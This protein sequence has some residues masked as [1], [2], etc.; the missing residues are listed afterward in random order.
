MLRIV[1]T[2]TVATLLFAPLA[3]GSSFHDALRAMARGDYLAAASRL[4][5]I[6][7]SRPEA[8]LA[9]LARGR[10]LLLAGHYRQAK[11][12]YASVLDHARP[13]SPY[14]Q[15]A[16]FGMAECLAAVKRFEPAERLFAEALDELTADK[17]R[18]AIAGRFVQLGDENLEPPEGR[19]AD[20]SRAEQFFRAAVEVGATGEM[21]E[22]VKI[23]IG[24]SLAAQNRHLDAA[25]YLDVFCSEHEKSPRLPEALYL[26][27]KAH[28][29]AGQPDTAR[30]AF[31]DLLA[32]HPKA[33][34]APRAAFLLS[35]TFGMPKPNNDRNLSWGLYTLGRY[36]HDWPKD[37][38]HE[39][40]RLEAALAPLHAKRQ[41][42]AEQALRIYI[43]SGGP[44]DN[45][46]SA[47]Y[48]LGEALAAQ[49][50]YLKAAAAFRDYLQKHPAHGFWL[51]ARRGIEDMAFKQAEDAFTG[52]KWKQAIEGF[53]A[54]T[55][56]YPAAARTPQ[57][58]LKQALA[59]I[60]LNDI[61]GALTLLSTLTT[62]FPKDKSAADGWYR[63]GLLLEEK[64]ADIMKAR[65]AYEKATQS[66]GG[67]SH[68]S[69]RLAALDEPGL[70]VESP[71][72]FHS[73]DKPALTWHARNVESVKVNIYH[74]E[75]EDF[76]KDRMQMES[77]IDMDIALCAPDKTFDVPVSGY[78]KHIRITQ[79]VP[80]KIKS[81]G[82]YLVHLM[83]GELEAT[84][85][86]VV[87]DL[88]MIIKNGPGKIFVFSQNLKKTLPMGGT[89]II[90]AD[91]N[92]IVAEGK[93]GKDGV[94]QHDLPEN[95]SGDGL[96][97]LAIRGGHLAWTGIDYNGGQPQTASSPR[98]FIFTDRPAYRPGD[99]VTIAGIVRDRP[100]Q[101]ASGYRPGDIVHIDVNLSQAKL[102]ET[103]KLDEFG[104]F[105]KKITLDPAISAG[106]Y[107]ISV[108]AHR[109][110]AFGC[111][112]NVRRYRL[113]A[114]DLSASFDQ[115]V[116]FR[117]EP[118]EGVIRVRHRSGAPAAFEKISY[119]LDDAQTWRQATC[120]E[121]GQVRFSFPTRAME[122][123]H[124]AVLQMKLPRLNLQ[125]EATAL[126]AAEGYSVSLSAGQKTI[127]AGQSFDLR[128]AVNAPDGKP[129]SANL[130]LRAVKRL[131]GTN[132]EVRVL[133]RKIE[134]PPSGKLC[135]PV[136]LSGKGVHIIRIYGSDRAGH[137][138]SAELGLSTVGEDEP[139]FFLDLERSELT[140]GAPAKMII[141]SHMDRALVLL[142]CET[143]E[144]LN[145]R[146][147]RLSRGENKIEIP[148]S[149]KLVPN[150][151]LAAAAMNKDRLY[152]ASRAVRVT[153]KL[154]LTVRPDHKRY[155]PGDEVNLTLIARDADGHPI[156]ARLVVA[157]VDETL[158]KV[159]PE[160]LPD[161][162]E[163][164]QQLRPEGEIETISSNAYRFP[165]VEASEVEKAE[166]EEAEDSA[167]M[168]ALGAR[169]RKMTKRATADFSKMAKTEGLVGGSM[170]YGM[171]AGGL[172]AGGRGRG[173]GGK[174]YMRM[175]RAQ[176]SGSGALRKYFSQTAA[177]FPALRTGRDGVANVT[178][179][180]PDTLTTWRI[181]TRG[182]TRD[183][184]LGEDRT[185][186][187]ASRQF[188]AELIA[189]P[190]LEEGD[191]LQPAARVY[192]DSR[193]KLEAT[194]KLAV[195]GATFSQAVT[196]KPLGSAEVFFKSLSVPTDS[197]GKMRF[198][199]SAAAGDLSDHLVRELPV[200]PRGVREQVLAS[201]LLIKSTSRTMKLDEGLSSARIDLRLDA[202]LSHIILAGELDPL[203]FGDRPEEALVALNILE[204]IG[205]RANATM[206]DMVM[207]RLR[208]ALRHL[209][210]TQK[211]NGGWAFSRQ[212]NSSDPVMTARAL[213]A[214]A[215]ARKLEGALGWNFPQ[216]GYQKALEILK[217][218]LVSL[219]PND[220]VRRVEVIYAL[221]H[222]GRA[223]IPQVHLQR[224]HR[225][226][227]SLPTGA[228]A[229][230]GL[231]WSLLD[232]PEKAAELAK[233]IR[234]ALNQAASG[235]I[236]F[237]WQPRWND[238]TCERARAL[239][240]LAQVAPSDPLVKQGT[241]WLLGGGTAFGWLFPEQAEAVTAA[242]GKTLAAP[243]RHERF[244][245]TISLNGSKAASLSFPSAEGGYGKSLTID[246]ALL[247]TG[248]NKLDLHLEGDGSCIFLATLSGYRAKAKP[249]AEQAAVTLK[250][251]VEPLPQPYRGHEIAGGFSVVAG[252]SSTWI[253]EI[254]SIPAGRRVRVTL[255]IKRNFAT[256]LSHCVLDERIP[257]GFELVEG[258]QSGYLAHM[259]QSGRRLAF[260][261]SSSNSIQTISY[262][263]QAT[264]P[265]RY[266]FAPARLISVI[267]PGT[268]VLSAGRIFTIDPPGARE[269]DRRT[270]PDELYHLGLAAADEK[271]PSMVIEKL[272]QLYQKFKLRENI[273]RDVQARLLF[274]SI[275]LKD[276]QRIVK[277]FEL[278]KEKNPDLVIPFDKIAPL[279]AA[280]RKVGS[281]EAGLHLDRGVCD[282][283]FMSEV[284]GVGILETQDEMAE[285]IDL[286][287]DQLDSYPDAE[288]AARATYAFSQVLFDRADRLRSGEPL[289][290]FDRPGLI[291][292]VVELMSRYLGLFPADPQAPAAVYSLASALLER[293][294]PGQAIDWC[295]AGLHRFPET[296]LSPAIAYLQAFAHF[297]LGQY[298]PSLKLCRQVVD[299]SPD[300]ENQD[301]ARYIMA[302]IFHA[303]GQLER[304]LPLYRMVR[305]S[306][307]DAEETVR[308]S[309][310]TLLVV[311]EV[312]TVPPGKRPT[313]TM[314]VRNLERINLRAYRVDPMSLYLVKGSL[315]DL[316]EVNLAGIKPV[317]ATTLRLKKRVGIT[318]EEKEPLRLP[319]KGAYL[320]L[321]HAGS[322]AEHSL[323]MVGG[324]SLDVTEIADEGRVRVTVRTARG[325]PLPGARVQLKGTEDERFIVGQTDLRGIFIA[326]DINGAV[327][328]IA[329]DAGA[330]GLYRGTEKLEGESPEPQPTPDKSVRYRKKTTYDFEDDAINGELVKP[331][332][333]ADAKNFF[334]QRVD[335]MSAQQAK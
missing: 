302:Q 203:L 265:G 235:K 249:P 115:S 113:P 66:P 81:P 1:S 234:N 185:K 120:D 213:R 177:F 287:R 223:Q 192:N 143:D 317:L 221:A 148:L 83:A 199:L 306:F 314:T 121:R 152:T 258:S 194:V 211:S 165:E 96:R 238:P 55:L 49:K 296:D 95:E 207:A 39:Q 196:I 103:A 17:R 119:R 160:N 228:Q 288:P 240:L 272:E 97:A 43:A 51:Q 127:F 179:R 305:D 215:R 236:V 248:D 88:G 327:T 65:Q 312:I 64:R 216:A 268:S 8:A 38:H 153:R 79:Q 281:H 259:A 104:V 68:A 129:R 61:A 142:T 269:V 188:W 173:G 200:V 69:A 94:W 266:Y 2:I 132:A 98:A 162:I 167:A 330:F 263:L 229:M 180:L 251:H 151:V 159:F 198:E 208:R 172:G 182:V 186:L 316:S 52:K 292:Q 11:K 170:G 47:R 85:A 210:I 77:V 178:F 53:A 214:L 267:N 136:S 261:L 311:P 313:L 218:Y 128:I 291:D 273:A 242:L 111:S 257:P 87:S 289:P 21:A 309:Q 130:R 60:E 331:A 58:L 125:Q 279:Q 226:R 278:A 297:K 295:R 184:Q 271:Q 161:L 135:L 131:P 101:K 294:S 217:G 270:T 26:A 19:V 230:L 108:R 284:H 155:G 44:A 205:P 50:R 24:R 310:K 91:G 89:R 59:K 62:K 5:G 145:Y 328:V 18:R 56:A 246:P 46:A 176:A 322:H 157:V 276:A 42:E 144:I 107:G 320:L 225:L 32:L 92:K 264:N 141:R 183:T 333:K 149:L 54:F 307:R 106:R 206:R 80:L 35:R 174:A 329:R 27:G 274:A 285:A 283:R 332:G 239:E 99:S 72:V 219:Q 237:S 163:T 227:S 28:L 212:Q 231:T 299:E 301:M 74:I 112:F 262:I 325:K 75:A 220:F 169:R 4:A 41:A 189:P 286:L 34:R 318:R 244:R 134:V 290:G 3:W 315:S 22:Q 70:V 253:N 247:R 137:P 275:E 308:E 150:F 63:T 303:R 168:A 33:A 209:V 300:Q 277:Y 195:A 31:T 118:L 57:A 102:T 100:G 7:A 202:R 23:K 29:D 9:G 76:F 117:G 105:H 171:G 260:Y 323:V 280:Y 324:L 164:F 233:P 48:H 319:G 73:G 110:A 15:K 25:R 116:V 146:T 126:V 326:S 147:V 45:L 334:Q 175:G 241:T 14:A 140:M 37:E 122:Q 222:E 114:Y 304:A 255:K 158:Y 254:E 245:V 124:K 335:G 82:L 282:A 191:S 16:R 187:V 10:A 256:Q 40:A 78:R 139:G 293:G 12:T 224:M 13:G 190:A 84:T 321:L 36:I 252:G 201:G 71:P 298:G 93:T 197:A 193:A 109:S 20:P 232:R 204:Q 156:D 166:V 30:R 67:N 181:T 90:V 138:I 154:V 6:P 133:D 250:R 123:T 86:V 243:N